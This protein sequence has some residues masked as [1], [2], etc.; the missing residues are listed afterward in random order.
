[1]LYNNYLKVALASPK[2]YL[3]KPLDNA[4]EIINILNDDT[5]ATIIAFPE[6]SLT[7][8]N[9][10]DLVYNNGFLDEVN[11]ALEYVVNNSNEKVLIIGLP[12]DNSGKLYNC[13]CIIQNKEILGLIPKTNLINT[14]VYNE[15]RYFTSYN[16]EED[17]DVISILDQDVPFGSSIFQDSIN[18][19]AFGVEIGTDLTGIVNPHTMNFASGAEFVFNISSFSYYMDNAKNLKNMVDSVSLKHKTAYLLVSSNSSTTSS[20][21]VYNSYQIASINGNTLLN[22]SSFDFNNVINYVDID[23]EYIK[24]QRRATKINDLN[25]GYV[26]YFIETDLN[27]L[28][29]NEFKLEKIPNNLPFVP[30]SKDEFD[31]I[32]NVTSCGLM[33]RLNH[34]AINKVVIGISGGLDSTLA[35]LFA[36]STFKKYNIDIKN[37]IAITMPG[38]GTGN[39]SK[40]IAK[41]LMEKLGVTALEI[42]IKKEA[43]N[44][45]K[46]I[47]HNLE[48]KDTTY[49]NVQARLRTLTLMSVANKEK[50]IVIGTGDMSEIALG[51]STF[52]GDQM[53]MYS[54]NSGLPKTTIKALVAYYINLIPEIKSELKKVYNATISP[55]LTGSDQ[56]TEDTIGKYEINDFI[57]YQLFNSGASLNRIIFLLKEVFNL[58]ENVA[59]KYYNNFLKRFKNNQFKRLTGAEGIK[60]FNVSLSPRNDLKYPGDLK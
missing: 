53:S 29:K 18:D 14:G 34:I 4:K 22:K 9:I 59:I 19:I 50:A 47:G 41:N 30:N 35:L 3:G 48:N 7:G 20:D 5:K 52:G 32:I 54:L 6:L 58:D 60:I 49:E 26:D 10:G 36:Y 15:S 39:K 25:I 45:L 38:M 51:W 57:M 21:I 56:A 46:A 42:S 44:H 16:I 31:E 2:V 12:I 13:A 28:E 40:I 1:M 8:C 43:M 55:E 11:K 17:S 24:Y 37:I 27:V 23:L 33:H